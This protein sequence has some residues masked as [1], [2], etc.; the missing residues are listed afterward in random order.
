MALIKWGGIIIGVLIALQGIQT[1]DAVQSESKIK[2][3]ISPF[4]T[5]RRF[6]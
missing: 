3:G 6:H 2:V 4:R 1:A 5:N